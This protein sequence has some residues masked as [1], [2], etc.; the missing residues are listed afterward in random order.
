MR[1]LLL[2]PSIGFGG[3]IERVARAFERAW[4]GPLDRVDLYCSARHGVAAGNSLA[5]TI[6]ARKAL[7]AARRRPDVV[8]ALH[9]GLLPVAAAASAISRADTALMAI[10]REVWPPMRAPRRAMVKRCSAVLAISSFTRF[11]IARR[12]G[13]A[14]EQVSLVRLPVDESLA[15][16][17]FRGPPRAVSEPNLLSV[18]RINRGERYKG[19]FDIAESLPHVLA[20]EPDA[21]W[22]VAGHGDDL[23]ELKARCEGLG[24][25]EAVSFL[26]R[27]SDAQLADLYANA[28]VFVLP[29][30]ADAAA[31]SPS[32][33]GFGLVYAEAGAFA[34]PSIASAAGGGSLDFV[35]HERTG[36][37]VPPADPQALATAMLRLLEDGELHDRLGAAARTLVSEQ[38]LTPHFAASIRSALSREP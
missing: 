9:V 28:A 10:G 18:S 31:R 30:V 15:D 24:V 4:D 1:L 38:H 32:G 35:K 5:K 21:R 34:V 27:V 13:I 2:T 14:V 36:L 22:I 16:R 6:F 20:R 8:L 3:G 17:A 25:A 23:Q 26:G 7:A 19:L 29:S 37:T 33:E 12:A 11:W